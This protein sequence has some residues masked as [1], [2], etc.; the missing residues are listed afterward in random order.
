M[1]VYVLV[2]YRSFALLFD[3]TD[4]HTHT[5]CVHV[6]K[7]VL[8]SHISVFPERPLSIRQLSSHPLTLTCH[9]THLPPYQLHWWHNNTIV[10]KEHTHTSL[11]DGHASSFQ[12]TLSVAPSNAL[13]GTTYRCGVGMQI[14]PFY[15]EGEPSVSFSYRECESSIFVKSNK[16]C[17]CVK[18]IKYIR[19]GDLDTL[20]WYT[21]KFVCVL[22][23]ALCLIST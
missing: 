10:T 1:Y 12:N 4:T 3:S 22:K 18:S 9:T 8:I 7:V 21:E 11:L 19:D 16:Y 13:P 17:M 2:Y 23:C 20:Y 6:S 15:E 5:Y 14:Q